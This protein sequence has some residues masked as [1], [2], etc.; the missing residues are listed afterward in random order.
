MFQINRHK[1]YALK[2][3]WNVFFQMTKGREESWERAVASLALRSE[4]LIDGF[5]L[6][7][8]REWITRSLSSLAFSSY[9]LSLSLALAFSLSISKL[10]IFNLWLQQIQTP[11]NSIKNASQATSW[12]VPLNA[13][14]VNLAGCGSRTKSTRYDLS[15]TILLSK[16]GTF[17]NRIRARQ[18]DSLFPDIQ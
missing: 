14:R 11:V 18:L 15:T 17:I 4:C 7:T 5:T 12:F 10:L 2:M 1:H 8:I 16:G 6:A 3:S 9:S 13:S